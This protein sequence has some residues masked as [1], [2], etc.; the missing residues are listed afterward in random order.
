[1]TIYERRTC[2][3]GFGRFND[4]KHSKYS[5]CNQPNPLSASN[6]KLEYS[7]RYIGRNDLVNRY[8]QMQGWAH[9]YFHHYQRAHHLERTMGME[10]DCCGLTN[11]TNTPAWFIEGQA[12]LFPTLFWK[13]NFNDLTISKENQITFNQILN[14]ENELYGRICSAIICDLDSIYKQHKKAF[15]GDGEYSCPE[16]TELDDYRD[17]RICGKMYGWVIT[18]A[19]MGYISSYQTAFVD[20]FNDINKLGFDGSMEKHYGLTKLEFYKQYSDFMRSDP[21]NLAPPPGFFP[22]KLSEEVNFFLVE[23]GN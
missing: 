6:E 9:E 19:Y 4:F 22:T 3:G 11:L 15:L 1:M 8:G 5:F 10:G 2:L 14:R 17:T 20:F 18:A 7:K 16:F 13:E 23:S 21:S 12:N